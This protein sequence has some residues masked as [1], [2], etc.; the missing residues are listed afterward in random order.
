[1]IPM[2]KQFN[3]HPFSKFGPKTRSFEKTQPWRKIKICST[4]HLQ[5]STKGSSD[6]LKMH[7]RCSFD[8]EKKQYYLA[9]KLTANLRRSF[10]APV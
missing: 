5:T 6:S 8:S 7:P 4:K 10:K 1:M 3:M 9:F 2:P